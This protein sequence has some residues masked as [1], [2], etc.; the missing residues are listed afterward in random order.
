MSRK[1]E[2]R[3]VVVMA[4]WQMLHGLFTILYYSVFQRQAVSSTIAHQFN[5]TVPQASIFIVI[6]IFGT[7]MIGLGM[8]NLVAAKNYMKDNTV[9]KIGYWLVGVGLFSYF[10]MDIVSLI[11]AMGA[12]VWYLA[13][14]KSIHLNNQIT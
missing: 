11:L 4:S 14:N 3:L 10:V 1:I 8:F 2:R 9:N 7:L 13:K 5:G 6:N 12:G